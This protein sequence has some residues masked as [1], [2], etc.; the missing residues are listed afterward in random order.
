VGVE[1]QLALLWEDA[2]RDGTVPAA[3]RV[4]LLAANVTAS[5]QSVAVIDRMCELTGTAA[6]DRTHPLSRMRRDALALRSH[7][8][9]NGMTVEYAGQMAL[10][11]LDE[12]VRV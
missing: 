7:I 5:E 6:L 3:Q 2:E 10:G 9:V 12:Q 4:R 8:A 1:S 11:L